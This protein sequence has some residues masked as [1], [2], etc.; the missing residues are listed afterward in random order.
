M[1]NVVLYPETI[2]MLTW[3]N[4]VTP[5]MTIIGKFIMPRIL[6]SYI[7]CVSTS[8]LWTSHILYERSVSPRQNA[9]W[10]G[11]VRW[12]SLWWAAFKQGHRKLM[13]VRNCVIP[14]TLHN[15]CLNLRHLFTH[16]HI[17]YH[18]KALFIHVTMKYTAEPSNWC[19]IRAV[20]PSYAL[21]RV[22]R[23]LQF[24]IRP[25]VSNC[26]NLPWCPFL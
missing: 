25:P 24:M 22:K 12:G 4:T 15:G 26:L 17:I 3:S 8:Q 6:W 20:H 18:W 19:H 1:Y 23:N 14:H 9:V 10:R 13:N 2:R 11:T 21:P 16:G 7:D 5:K